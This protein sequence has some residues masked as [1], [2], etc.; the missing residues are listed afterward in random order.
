MA[1]YLWMFPLL[2]IFH[3]MEEI[4]GLVPWI[5]LNETLLAQK[6]PAILKI[7]K[8]ITTE[9][10][11]LAVFEEFILVLSITLLAYFSQSRALELVWLGGFVAFALH[12]FLHIGQSILLRKYIPA[13]ITSILCFP[14]SAYLITDIVYLWRVSTSEFFLFSLV[15]SGIVVINLLFALWL[16]KKY[17]A[18]LVHKNE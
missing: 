13:L 17:S 6:A 18:W 9:G 14:I 8:G 4:I 3:D 5:L 11:A 1:F 10:F 12:L 7:H 16:G 2:F 15:G